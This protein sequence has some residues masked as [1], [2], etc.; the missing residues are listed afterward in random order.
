MIAARHFYLAL[1][2][3]SRGCNAELLSSDRT[4]IPYAAILAL[5]AASSVLF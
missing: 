5:A 1:S 2:P 4:G 3:A